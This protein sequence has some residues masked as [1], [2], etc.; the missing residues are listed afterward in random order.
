[1]RPSSLSSR[2]AQGGVTAHAVCFAQLWHWGYLLAGQQPAGG[3]LLFQAAAIAVQGG[4]ESRGTQSGWWA[5]WCPAITV[6][7]ATAMGLRAAIGQA[8]ASD[9]Q[10]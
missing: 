6:H 8:I 2:S 4:S 10:A 1:M 3:Y 7:A 9:G 5:A